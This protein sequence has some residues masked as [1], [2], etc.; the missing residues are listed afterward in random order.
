MATLSSLIV[1]IGADT[2]EFERGMDRVSG[3]L[4]RQGQELTSVGR[5]LTMGV[6]MPIM[7]VATASVMTGMTFEKSM[8]NVQAVSGA[9]G[10]QFDELSGL[11]KDLGRTTKFSASEAADGMGYLAMAGFDVE[12]IMKAMPGV[13]QLAAA[14]NMDLAQT[15]D[16]ASNVLTGYGMEASEITRVND[17]MAATFTSANTDMAQLGEAMKYVAP[18][19]NSAG[20]K[21]E[22]VSAAIGMMGNAGIQGSMAGTSLRGAITRLLEPT[23]AAADTLNRLGIETTDSAGNMVPLVDIVRQLEESGATTADMM[24]IFGQRAGPAM[25]A[26][27]EQGA[28]ELLEFTEALEDSGGTAQRVADTQKEGRA[29]AFP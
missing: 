16:I 19:A 26:L 14:G 23:G 9:T 10:A 21:F 27:V 5:S 1:R 28:D 12:D 11:A 7:A 3:R 6:T 24:T 4:N 15:A 8:K 22:E 13:L 18:V 17:V 20:L 29:G 25:A 2:R